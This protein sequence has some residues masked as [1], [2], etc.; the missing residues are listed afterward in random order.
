MK[1]QILYGG[2]NVFDGF[3]TPFVGKSDSFV[4]LH[5]RW[6]TQ[7]QITLEGVITGSCANDFQELIDK[8]KVLLNN[9]S[10]D[11]QSLSI[12]EEGQTI[13]SAPYS[14][15][16]SISFDS[17]KYVRLVPYSISV[18]CFQENL[19]SGVYGVENPN[20]QITWAENEDGTVSVSRSISAK[21]FNTNAGNNAFEN[22]RNYVQSKTGWNVSYFSEA[23]PAFITYNAGVTLCA[24]TIKESVDRFGASYGVDIEYVY[25]PLGTSSNLL[26]YSVSTDY[27]DEDGIFAVSINGDLEACPDSNWTLLRQEFKNIDLYSIANYEFKKVYPNEPNLNF[28]YL[29]EEITESTNKKVISFSKSWDTDPRALVL[30]DYEINE[31]YSLI[32]DVWLLSLNGTI[33]ARNSQKVNWSRVLDY[34]QNNVDVFAILENFYISKGY[35]YQLVRYPTNYS[36]TENIIDATIEINASYS[37]KI[38]PPY[39]FDDG[40]YT[41]DITP[42]LNQYVP[43]PVLCGDYTIIDT[44]AKKRGQISVN[45]N[46]FKLSNVGQEGV[47]RNLAKS[48]L[49]QYI[50][51]PNRARV[52]KQDSVTTEKVSQGYKYSV[53]LTE[54]FEGE[55]FSL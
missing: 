30:F 4:R 32:D 29:N 54:K 24:K 12:V 47:V 7:T 3:P 49:N 36:V 42:P 37:D 53:N 5:D 2:N 8:Q 14:W 43:V 50:P 41:I 13:Y 38:Q 1:T 6:L 34:Y 31:E 22:A 51:T 52:V 15:I 19:F 28:E 45:G 23:L 25:N 39:G 46:L 17:N 10:R 18:N 16:D 33:S 48:I 44:R 35:P 40:D 20:Q 9:F 26:K 55:I 11:F 27:S 21:G